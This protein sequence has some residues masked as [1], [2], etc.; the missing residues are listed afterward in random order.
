MTTGE[1]IRHPK[2]G[3]DTPKQQ[4]SCSKPNDKDQPEIFD[5]LGFMK[6]DLETLRQTVEELRDLAWVQVM[7]QLLTYR[8]FKKIFEKDH[9][10]EDKVS[11]GSVGDGDEVDAS[12]EE[13][14][15]TEHPD[16]TLG[17]GHD[18]VKAPD[19]APG[20]VETNEESETG[21]EGE[22]LETESV[23]ATPKAKTV[24]PNIMKLEELE[25]SSG[26]TSSEEEG[27]DGES[28]Q[29]GNYL[30]TKGKKKSV[31]WVVKG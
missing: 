25:E 26:T 2:K 31:K 10:G 19:L 1:A 18:V 27:S 7:S 5:H 22:E 14:L 12:G 15:E 29:V 4:V 21:D 13:E 16:K 30:P 24:A 6:A 28:V 3:D 11:S 9:L 8:L 20:D 23:K 17:Q